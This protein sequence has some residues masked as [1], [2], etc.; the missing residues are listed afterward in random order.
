MREEELW[1]W[2]IQWK[3]KWTTTTEGVTEAEI[4]R[5]HPEA[6]RVLGSR[7]IRQKAETSEDLYRLLGRAGAP[8][9]IQQLNNCETCRHFGGWFAV[10]VGE[11]VSYRT[12]GECL[13]SGKSTGISQPEHGC[14][15]WAQKRETTACVSESP[16]G[17]RFGP[18][19]VFPLT[20]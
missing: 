9:Q 10:Q 17:P 7:C 8:W 4:R 6:I 12:H 16:G 19:A 15:H 18:D 2:R 1:D 3:G 14:V 13:Q 5:K 20:R 11:K